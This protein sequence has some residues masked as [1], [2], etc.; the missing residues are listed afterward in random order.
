MPDLLTHCRPQD[1]D[2]TAITVFA[3][4]ALICR[5]TSHKAVAD[6]EY[7]EALAVLIKHAAD[8]VF[9]CDRQRFVLASTEFGY[10]MF[11]ADSK[12][13]ATNDIT[14]AMTFTYGEDNPFVKELAFQKRTGLDSFKA[15]TI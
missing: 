1:V 8:P 3:S 14:E 6:A 13:E 11:I 9:T 10:D 12:G 15:R 7:A 4:R 2:A 5:A